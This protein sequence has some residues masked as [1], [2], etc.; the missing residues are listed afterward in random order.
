MDKLNEENDRK[1]EERLR[2]IAKLNSEIVKLKENLN[3]QKEKTE[4]VLI[5]NI[6]IKK[7]TEIQK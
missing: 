1:G 6:S 3:N 7:R 5:N 4:K 2:E